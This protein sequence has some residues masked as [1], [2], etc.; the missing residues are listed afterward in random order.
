[1]TSAMDW[2]LEVIVVPVTD[3]DR[4]TRFYAEGVGF[5]VDHDTRIGEGV[6]VVQLTPPG[7]ACSISF[8]TGLPQGEPGSLRGVQLVVAD[9]AAAR[10]RLVAGGVEA[11][12]V[13]HFDGGERR[14]GHGGP[15][16]AFVSFEDPDG[17]AWVVQERP[18][19]A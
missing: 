2:K 5:V 6:R 10:E 3:V 4:A 7:S 13:F 9:V 15:W 11:S 14:S 8:G 19:A 16:N 18:A 1:M 17:N 12:E